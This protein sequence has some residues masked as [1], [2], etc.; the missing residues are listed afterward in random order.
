MTFRTPLVQKAVEIVRGLREK[1]PNKTLIGV[2][3]RRED[4]ADI[5][6]NGFGWTVP[7]GDYFFNA[8]TYFR[9]RFGSSKVVFGVFTGDEKWFRQNVKPLDDAVFVRRSHS[10]AVDLEALSRFDHVIMS[11]G[12]YGWWAAYKNKGTVVAF[13]KVFVPGSKFAQFFNNDPMDFL[14]PS[15]V[16]L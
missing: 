1:F 9:Q 16:L 8:M 15:W 14:H 2:H 4:Y 10:A 3:V 5:A 11:V 6:N 7:D 13:K 12:T